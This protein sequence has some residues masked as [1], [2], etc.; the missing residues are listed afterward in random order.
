[1]D[2]VTS[3]ILSASYKWS[4]IESSIICRRNLAQTQ[5]SILAQMRSRLAELRLGYWSAPMMAD[6][7]RFCQQME[8]NGKVYGPWINVTNPSPSQSPFAGID[9]VII[10]AVG[11]IL[12]LIT[13]FVNWNSK[14]VRNGQIGSKYDVTDH[15]LL[16][17]ETQWDLHKN[18][19]NVCVCG[20]I[21]FFNL[22]VKCV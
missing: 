16:E 6:N 13:G 19:L 2:I 17:H 4:W 7:G 22:R 8:S 20:D 9:W 5:P 18:G 12:V 21:S 11:F 1:M 14:A 3:F 10:G 15:R